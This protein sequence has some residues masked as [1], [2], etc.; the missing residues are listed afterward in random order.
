MTN[1]V[2]FFL[3]SCGL[4]YDINYQI[5][6][7]YTFVFI[8]FLNV[9]VNPFIYASQFHVIKKCIIGLISAIQAK[10]SV[11]GQQNQVADIDLHM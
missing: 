11:G 4:I 6:V 9:G 10:L 1:E 8:T 3:L 2:Y 7:W 5:E